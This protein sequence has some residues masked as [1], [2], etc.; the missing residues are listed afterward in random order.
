M[1]CKFLFQKLVKCSLVPRP[2]PAFRN[3]QYGKA[4]KDFLFAHGWGEPGKK[5]DVFL[6]E[7]GGKDEEEIKEENG[8]GEEEGG[9][10]KGGG[11]GRERGVS[12]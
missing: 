3:L 4:V 9:E 10:G 8:E 5:A 12:L 11:E 6:E 7:Q 1:R 2:R